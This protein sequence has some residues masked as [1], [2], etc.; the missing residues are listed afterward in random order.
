MPTAILVDGG[1]FLKR[2]ATCYPD[3][4]VIDAK[5]A[6]NTLFEMC[7]HHFTDKHWPGGK[8]LLYR[9]FFYDCPPIQKKVHL[10]KSR[11]SLDFARQPQA[12]FRLAFHDELR[13]LRKTALRLGHLS[14]SGEWQLHEGVLRQLLSGQKQFMELTDDD[15]KYDIRQKGVDMRIGMDIA[16]LAYKRHVDQIVLFAGDSDFMPAAKLARVEGIDFVLDPMWGIITSQLE[17]HVD[18]VRSTAPRPRGKVP[19]PASSLPPI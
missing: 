7:L 13:R 11:R 14:D 2:V 17:E 19:Q 1:Y 5:V 15:F 18:G 6:A 16:S 8:R 10:P 3:R 4:N 12:I 9:I